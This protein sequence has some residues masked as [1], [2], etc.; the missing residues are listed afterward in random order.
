VN[1]GP[2][3]RRLRRHRHRDLVRFNQNLALVVRSLH[4]YRIRPRLAEVIEIVDDHA[5]L[6]CLPRLKRDSD[7]TRPKDA[8][9]LSL[10]YSLVFC[11]RWVFAFFVENF[12]PVTSFRSPGITVASSNKE[13][14]AR[15]VCQSNPKSYLRAHFDCRLVDRNSQCERLL[16]TRL[17]S[18]ALCCCYND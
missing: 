16:T 10:N 2:P 17:L 11:F 1:P 18:K 5:I 13:I 8:I 6:V 4:L 15:G 12:D 7:R 14:L 3:A 9:F